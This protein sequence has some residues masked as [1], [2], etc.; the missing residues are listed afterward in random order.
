LFGSKN[1]LQKY[2]NSFFI[3]MDYMDFKDFLFFSLKKL[4]L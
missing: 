1:L 3:N 2:K 4:S